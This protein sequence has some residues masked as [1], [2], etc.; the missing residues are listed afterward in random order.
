M[1][2]ELFEFSILWA[3]TW[4]LQ[5]GSI[6]T[7]VIHW[8]L[9]NIDRDCDFQFSK[10]IHLCKPH[11][12]SLLFWYTS[13]ND[14]PQWIQKFA[15]ECI[16]IYCKTPNLFKNFNFQIDNSSCFG[17]SIWLKINFVESITI[18]ICKQGYLFSTF[19][20]FIS[21]RSKFKQLFKPRL[22]W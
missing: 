9:S 18:V 21:Y 3:R 20:I 10:L 13:V 6:F 11:E 12:F 19:F 17:Q 1:E 22:Y 4:I 15:N 8:Y 5:K 7:H 2:G 14:E 16:C